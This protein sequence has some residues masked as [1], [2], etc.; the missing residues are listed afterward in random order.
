MTVA[1]V[2]EGLLPTVT[3]SLAWGAQRMAERHALVRHLEAVETLGST[4][5]IC[6]DKTGTLTR[7]EMAV[8]EAWTPTAMALDRRR[9]L[10][11]DRAGGARRDPAARHAVVRLA[12]AGAR[13]STGRVRSSATAVDRRT[14]TRW[15]RRI[16]ALARRLG[17][18]TDADRAATGHDRFPFDPRRRR[19]SVRRRRRG[20][21]QGRA[22]RRPAALPATPTALDASLDALAAQGLRVLA[23]AA[24]RSTG[25][26]RQRRPTRSRPGL[27]AARPARPRGPAPPSVRRRP[28]RLPPRRHPRWP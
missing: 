19:M 27:D 15:R 20:R 13:C 22:R 12:R 23:V 8:V 4:T 26:R 1:L 24:G 28:R 16:D 9:R 7:N 14:A 5:F 3:L 6:T 11:P 17:L 18:D 10:R 21:R 2:P 25:P